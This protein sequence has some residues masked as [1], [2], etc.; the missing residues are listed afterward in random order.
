MAYGLG[1]LLNKN[2]L[3]EKFSLKNINC[4]KVKNL[5]I[6]IILTHLYISY[7]KRRILVKINLRK[8]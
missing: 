8:H 2:Q 1:Y 6:F 5:L 3:S 4:K 7:I